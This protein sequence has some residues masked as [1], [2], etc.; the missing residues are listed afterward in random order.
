MRLGICGLCGEEGN[1]LDSDLLPSAIYKSM[2]ASSGKNPNPVYVKPG[3]AVA[4]S[5]EVRQHFLCGLCEDRLNNGGERWIVRNCYQRDGS[6]P[7]RDR[8]IIGPP[9]LEMGVEGGLYESRGVHEIET[10]RKPSEP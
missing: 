4:T 5:D 9:A 3:A 1:L 8:L 2:K 6:F 7:L 10:G